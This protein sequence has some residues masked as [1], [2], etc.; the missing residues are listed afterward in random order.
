PESVRIISQ[1][2]E[3]ID[4]KGYPKGLSGKQLSPAVRIVG[5]VNRYDNLCNPPHRNDAATPAEALATLFKREQSHW[6]QNLLQHLVRLIGVY[7]PGSIVQL[8]N[9]NIGIVVSV[10]RSD[11]LRPSIML[12]DPGTPRSEAIIVDLTASAGVKIDAVLRPED[13]SPPVS[14]Y[15][16]PKRQLSYFHG[17]RDE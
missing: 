12:Y 15:L 3:A 7:P 17:K 9:G 16:A 8:S 5:M 14:R 11:L 4:G 10:D 1:H 13:L 6:D 2:H